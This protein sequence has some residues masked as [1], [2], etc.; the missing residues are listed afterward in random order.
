VRLAR[1]IGN[2]VGVA[3]VAAYLLVILVDQWT[4]S[5]D[6]QSYGA[7]PAYALRQERL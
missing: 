1:C 5:R 7:V 4:D 2:C 3:A 6:A